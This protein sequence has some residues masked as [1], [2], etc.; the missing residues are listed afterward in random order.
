MRIGID[1][2]LLNE[3]GVG[4]YIKNLLQ[5]LA[6]IDQKN[7]YIIFLRKNAYDSFQLPGRR[8][9]KCLADVPWHSV[10]EQL[11]MPAIFYREKLDTLHV[12][13]FNV[14]VLYFGKFIVTIH[15]LTILHFD[16]GRATTLPF[17]FYTLRR[18]GYCVALLKAIF[19]SEK[20]IAVSNTTKKE[21]L[22]HF[23]VPIEHIEVIYE[24]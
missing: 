7:E 10:A 11:F 4:R 13:Y 21:I 22:D 6:V 19:R 12:P 20:V 15:D 14:P 5:E 18:I 2:R 16:T 17:I 3:T 1:A 8:W 24:G 23:H 9:S